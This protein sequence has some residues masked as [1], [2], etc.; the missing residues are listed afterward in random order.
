MFETQP[1][2]ELSMPL[3]IALYGDNPGIKHWHAFELV[4]NNFWFVVEF[5]ADGGD[6]NQYWKTL[7][8]S[9]LN[10][11][12]DLVSS[13]GVLEHRINMVIPTH[14]SGIQQLKMKPV[15][16]IYSAEENGQNSMTIY[17]A[18]DG[19]RYVD[20]ALGF[21]ESQAENKSTVYAKKD[22]NIKSYM[23]TEE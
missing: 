19:L 16:T 14:H 23:A 1:N 17:V 20:S 21:E 6:G 9:N 7:I 13:E 22:I 12:L 3:P 18:S 5:L 15:V 8:V 4:L 2:Y 11:V 10:N